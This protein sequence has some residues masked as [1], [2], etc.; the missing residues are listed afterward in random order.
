M[1]YSNMMLRFY[2]CHR[3]EFT[4]HDENLG[5]PNHEIGFFFKERD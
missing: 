1:T 2:T 3:M 5:Q 4:F